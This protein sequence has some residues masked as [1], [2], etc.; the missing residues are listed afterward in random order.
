MI[1]NYNIK[2]IFYLNDKKLS[3]K[4]IEINNGAK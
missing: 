3:I 4:P 1:D 2:Y